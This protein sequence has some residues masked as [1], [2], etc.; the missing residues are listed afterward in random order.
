MKRVT[1][2]ISL[3]LLLVSSPLFAQL[4]ASTLHHF[5]SQKSSLT[6]QIVGQDSVCE[7]S[8]ALYFA[9]NFGE[10]DSLRW[11]VVG[12]ASID[13]TEDGTAS[14]S[15]LKSGRIDLI[16][17]RYSIWGDGKQEFQIL[18][19]PAPRLSLGSDTVLCPGESIALAARSSFSAFRSEEDAKP[20]YR[21]QDGSADDELLVDHTGTYWVMAWDK[22][23]CKGRDIVRVTVAE[24]PQPDLG[25]DLFT[26]T[27]EPVT[28]SPGTFSVYKW[29]DGSAASELTVKKPGKYWVEVT[30]QCGQKAIDTLNISPWKTPT[31]N[32]GKDLFTCERDTLLLDAGKGFVG[33]KWTGGSNK[34]SIAATETGTYWVTALDK[35]GCEVTDSVYV[36]IEPCTSELAIP[37]AFSPNGDGLN[38]VFRPK[39]AQNLAD[40]SIQIFDPSGLLVYL[41]KGK[42]AAWN[43]QFE[44]RELPAG[45]YTYTIQYTA[46]EGKR[47]FDAGTVQLKR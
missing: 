4:P 34:Q 12:N 18:V 42:N 6:P 31:I 39:S 27:D 45:P 13:C 25:K 30:D 14:L 1:L 5:L 15:F 41:S 28:L 43:G 26:C 37:S 36:E 8:T 11:E 40:F 20:T 29:Q 33:Y 9:H 46:E 38:D 35:A 3:C 2:S 19:M 10:E 22:F 24:T 47:I 32:L 44:K 23:G 17:H 21:W 7:G 16:L